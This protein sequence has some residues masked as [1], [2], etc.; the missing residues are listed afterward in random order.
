MNSMNLKDAA[1]KVADS[2]GETL[3][4]SGRDA[5]QAAKSGV[6]DIAASAGAALRDEAELRAEEG[7]DM[8]ADQGQRLA[9]GLRDAASDRGESSVQGRVLETIAGSVSDVSEGLRDRSVMSLLDDVQGFARRNPGIFMAA[10]AL[11]GFAV[12]RFAVA[13]ARPAIAD[14]DAPA[15]PRSRPRAVPRA[16]SSGTSLSGNKSSASAT[17][18]TAGK[19]KKTERKA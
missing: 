19:T 16:K 2:V 5:L 8:L 6:S 12:A 11:A 13:S 3:K 9:S 14:I 1:A 10:A 7:K 15:A 18:S 4:E 17:R